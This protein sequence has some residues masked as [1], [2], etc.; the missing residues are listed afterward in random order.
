[1]NVENI[2]NWRDPTEKEKFYINELENTER[3]DKKP[4][5]RNKTKLF[6]QGLV[7][8]VFFYLFFGKGS[9]F[10]FLIIGYIVYQNYDQIK[11]YFKRILNKQNYK[12]EYFN[13]LINDDYKVLDVTIEK[14]GV[15]DLEGNILEI[16][17]KNEDGIYTSKRIKTYMI[18]PPLDGQNNS[19]H[20]AILIRMNVNMPDN[21]FE[22]SKQ[23]DDSHQ[24]FEYHKYFVLKAPF[25]KI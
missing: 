25:D 23:I 24:I 12:T 3:I 17:Y 16:N 21:K 13:C 10:I 18:H 8:V 11:N 4:L 1:M 22:I 14:D 20:R 19:Y 2:T 5:K 6:F 9:I 15:N 7:A